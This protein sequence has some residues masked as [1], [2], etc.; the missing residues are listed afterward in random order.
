M[1]RPARLSVI[2]ALALAV[3][4][5]ACS[6]PA[7]DASS[8]GTTTAAAASVSEAP[9]PATTAEPTS[10]TITSTTSTA[11]PA[12]TTPTPTTRPPASST[13]AP[14]QPDDRYPDQPDGVPWPTEEWSVGEP[15]PGVDVAAI[16]DAV[17]AA[18]G[19]ADN[20]ARL[21]AFVMVH[22]GQ[23]VYERYHP[24]DDPDTVFESYSVA[25]S[26]TSTLVGMLVDDGDLDVTA[27]APVEEW[28]GP[29]DPR[30]AITLEHLLQMRSGLAWE[31]IYEPGRPPLEMLTS[32]DWAAYVIDQPLESE[33]GA[34][35]DYSTG[36]TAVL[37]EIVADAVGG[38]EALDAFI[39]RELLEPLGIESTTLI[40]D[41][42]GQFVGGLGFDSSARDFARFGLMVVRGGEWDG[43][44]IV[45]STWLDA[46]TAPSPALAA[47]GYQWW[48]DPDGDWFAARGLFGQLILVVP[49]LDLVIVANTTQGGNSET[50][51]M[52]AL[53]AFRAA[54]G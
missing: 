33:P 10:T 47:Y 16:D 2:P 18:F 51:A 9:S 23:I 35:F 8:S 42:T 14:T 15:P 49:E 4:M 5:V 36:T 22:G 13:T 46:A 1:K 19:P 11:G 52:T 21:R 12:A 37:A 53:D 24:L 32:P 17:E 38:P 34:M 45:S 44:Q 54:V 7:P 41:P 6:E 30:S 50:P 31:E 29:G 39:E 26:V 40:E 48:L 27:P 28:A 3:V 20:S 25:K 43:Q